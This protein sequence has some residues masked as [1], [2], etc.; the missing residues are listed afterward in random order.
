MLKE[1]I[2]G[3]VK[4]EVD[5]RIRGLRQSIWNDIFEK[6]EHP[7]KS[8]IER[9]KEIE[10]RIRKTEADI[11]ELRALERE[12]EHLKSEIESIAWRAGL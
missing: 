5:K 1:N 10:W 9:L 4:D 7:I 8:S 12:V 11:E 2:W 6:L 3:L